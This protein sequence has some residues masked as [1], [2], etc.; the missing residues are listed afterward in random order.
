[1]LFRSGDV[2][3]YYYEY[4][5]V[6]NF[7]KRN[8]VKCILGNHDKMA[9]DVLLGEQSNLTDLVTMYGS[10]YNQIISSRDF[11]LEYLCQL[12]T[13]YEEIFNNKKVLMVHGSPTDELH[14]RIYP[15]TRLEV[16]EWQDYDLY[17]CGDRK[18]TRLNSSHSSVSRM[19]SSA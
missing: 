16:G 8:Y 12:D 18:S 1:M 11:Y 7:L 6:I 13:H 4:E 9:I 3:G 19:P 17:F 2:F 10:G 15:S 5:E 14:G